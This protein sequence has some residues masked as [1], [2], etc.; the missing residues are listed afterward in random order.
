MPVDP[1]YLNIDELTN[2]EGL[3]SFNGKTL[4]PRYHYLDVLARE[5]AV[6]FSVAKMMD[7]D[8]LA[9][10]Q[11][12]LSDALANST[13]FDVFKK[14]MEP[15][16]MSKGWWGTKLEVDPVT[17]DA[18]KVQLGSTRRLRTIYHT[19]LHASYAAGQ[20]QRIQETKRGLPYLQYM[21]SVAGKPRNKHKMYYN[22]VRPVD[23]P[24]WHLIMPPN[25][26]GCLCWVKQLTRSQA[27]RAGIS[28]EVELDMVEV[29]NPRTGK[30]ERIPAGLDPSFAHNHDRLTAVRK[31]QAEKI[32]GNKSLSAKE[33]EDALAKNSAQLDDYMSRLLFNPAIARVTPNVSSASFEARVTALSKASPKRAAEM[34]A[35]ARGTQESHQYAV[36]TLSASIQDKLDVDKY[37]AWMG[38]DTLLTLIRAAKNNAEEVVDLLHTTRDLLTK[39]HTLD[40]I[41]DK[42]EAQFVSGDLTY[43]A[44]LAVDETTDTLNIINLETVSKQ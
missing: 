37:I 1:K 29:E 21:P 10:T 35:I 39:A 27:R 14:R 11:A 25:G 28:D 24:I 22:I 34:I 38:E 23:D 17:G 32:Q 41:G 44:T 3:A 13:D 9:E 2:V 18:R 40:K 4:L 20:W 42:Y 36:A 7:E 33:K 8:I 12:A 15:Y 26:Y 31:M 19:N 6:A 16:L 43:K 5:H 30:K